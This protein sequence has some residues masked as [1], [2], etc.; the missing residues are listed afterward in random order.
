MTEY[1]VPVLRNHFNLFY[2]FGYTFIP[3]PLLLQLQ[4]GITEETKK[5]LVNKF[6]FLTPFE[7]DEEYLILKITSNEPYQTDNILINIQDVSTIYPLSLQ[8]KHS[9]ESKIDPRI[10]LEEPIFETILSRIE[11]DLE[12]KEIQKAVDA[13]WQICKI[14][15][16]KDEI[17]SLIGID[18]LFEGLNFRKQGRK[19]STIQG[20]NYWS[21]LIAYDRF[22]YYPNTTIGY[23]YDAAQVFAY[24]KNKPTFE[25]S[26]L[27]H[28]L[29]KQNPKILADKLVHLL[30]TD[31]QTQKY[32]AQTFN[33]NLKKYLVAPLFLNLKDDLRNSEDLRNSSFFKHLTYY[34]KFGKEFKA[35]IVLL[36]AFFGF[37]KF[38]DI[39]YD[40]LN[41]RFYKSY[42][43]EAEISEKAAVVSGGQPAVPDE[44]PEE[45]TS[46]SLIPL[47]IERNQTEIVTSEIVA[48]QTT[49]GEVKELQE[50]QDVLSEPEPQIQSEEESEGNN[51]RKAIIEILKNR[52]DLSL[53]ELSKEL[54][55]QAKRKFDKSDIENLLKDIPDDV[56]GY[57]VKR[58]KKFRLRKTAF[59]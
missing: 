15:G 21:I 6:Q 50:E 9:I 30:E 59:F 18:N 23:F 36:G 49:E 39:Y 47:K 44:K 10:K 53:T 1:L 11:N 26:D 28:F 22:D 25:G 2:R 58:T 33:N 46:N 45:P 43:A 14:E 8:A 48:E 37:K 34:K 7:Y 35:A 12:K 4:N 31:E 41:L 38:Y 19:A 27:Y 57:T 51:F 42:R 55:K 17:E 16:E 3:K 5:E 54:N 40:H 20:A 32:I 24:S 29:A 13:L 52:H 56:E